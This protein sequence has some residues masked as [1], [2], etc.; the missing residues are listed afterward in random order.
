MR[1]KTTPRL[2]AE[3]LSTLVRLTPAMP[4]DAGEAMPNEHDQIER[5]GDREGEARVAL[6]VSLRDRVACGGASFV[7]CWRKARVAHSIAA[8]EREKHV[9]AMTGE[10]SGLDSDVKEDASKLA[11]FVL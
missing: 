10:K 5:K 6:R 11:Q 4:A 9:S 3:L 2:I 1:G 7:K 8:H